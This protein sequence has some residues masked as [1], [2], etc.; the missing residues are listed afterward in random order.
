MYELVDVVV[1]VYVV[2]CC[3]MCNDFTLNFDKEKGFFEKIGEV[4]EIVF[5]VFME[6]IGLFLDFGI[7]GWV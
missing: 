7:F 1:V 6:K 3:L 2:M 5:C 4:I